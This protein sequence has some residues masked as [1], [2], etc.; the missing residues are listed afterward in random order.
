MTKERFKE[1][2]EELDGESLN[3]LTTKNA[4]YSS[5]N[6]ALHNFKVGAAISGM[7]PA[8]TAWGYMTKHLT[9]LRDKI[10]RDDFADREDLLEKIQDSINYLRFIWAIANE[11]DKTT[12]K[13]YAKSTSAS[14]EDILAKD[15]AQDFLNAMK[16]NLFKKDIVKDEDEKEKFWREP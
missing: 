12:Y 2:L 8:Q 6:D 5:E 9:A 3:T 16:E 10:Q 1:L 15:F 7:T 13:E 14:K 4:R 11:G